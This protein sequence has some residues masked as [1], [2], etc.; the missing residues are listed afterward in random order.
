[1]LGLRF[2]PE[3]NGSHGQWQTGKEQDRISFLE[4]I[5]GDWVV[6]GEAGSQEIQVGP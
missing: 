1:M 5:S 6:G 2:S 3:G 4:G